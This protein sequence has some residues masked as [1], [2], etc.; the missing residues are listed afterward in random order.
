MKKNALFSAIIVGSMLLTNILPVV[1]SSLTYAAPPPLD[2]PSPPVSPVEP[3]VTA[4]PSQNP[5]APDDLAPEMEQARA[6]RAME[7]ALEKYLDYWGPR[8]QVAPVEV[9]V[10]G[11]W[12]HGVAD[13]RGQ[14]RTL[15]ESVHVLAHRLPDGTWQALMPSSDGLYLQ[16]LEAVPEKVMTLTEKNLIR[17]QIQLSAS[18]EFAWTTYINQK[19]GYSVQLP[20]NWSAKIAFTN[21]DNSSPNVIREGITLV[22]GEDI[23]VYIDTWS[24]FGAITLREWLDMYQVPM[25]GWDS[26]KLPS[27]QYASI[28]G[29]DAV[30]IVQHPSTMHEQIFYTY[31]GMSDRVIRVTYVTRDHGRALEIYRQIVISLVDLWKTS[32]T[33]GDTHFP[34]LTLVPSQVTGCTSVYKTTCCGETASSAKWPCAV[35]GGSDLGNCTWWAAHERPDVGNDSHVVGDACQW[36]GQAEQSGFPVDTTPQIGDIMVSGWDD[37]LLGAT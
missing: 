30:V 36:A 3:S 16:W 13:W 15:S 23:E 10:E 31:V 1:R 2:T 12:A 22:G 8:Y 28:N 4:Q 6:R 26:A 9:A 14:A 24:V 34:A 21:P 27:D 20:A 18:N 33:L 32:D 11:E 29:M 37:P 19:W 17:S 25:L 5:P 7:A 35:Q